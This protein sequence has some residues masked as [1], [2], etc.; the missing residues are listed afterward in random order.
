MGRISLLGTDNIAF[1]GNLIYTTNDNSLLFGNNLVPTS[2]STFSI[3]SSANP[4]KT[5][6]ISASTLQMAAPPG[7]NSL[8]ILN[9]G[10]NFQISNG[11]LRST[12][13]YTGGLLLSGN[14]I[15]ADPLASNLPM[16]IGTNGLPALQILVP[17]TSTST[18]STTNNLYA[19]GGTKTGNLTASKIQ[20][21]ANGNPFSAFHYGSGEIT[22]SSVTVRD[23]DVTRNSYIFI[24]INSSQTG[25]YSVEPND[26]EFVLH[27]SGF[28]PSPGPGPSTPIRFKYFYFTT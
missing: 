2:I 19:I 12:V 3:G 25:S 23:R 7:G 18:I 24:T 17:T 6:F 26:G 10:S 11:G 5:L 15:G 16:T 28:S 9:D 27:T 14:N 8:S 22:S 20:I 21:G 4:F 13:I 1:S